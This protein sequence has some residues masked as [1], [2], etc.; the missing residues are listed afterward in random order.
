MKYQIIGFL[1]PEKQIKLDVVFFPLE[2]LGMFMMFLFSLG[3]SEFSMVSFI[4]FCACF[5]GFSFM[6][7][8]L[9]TFSCQNKM[10]VLTVCK[11]VHVVPGITVALGYLKVCYTQCYRNVSHC[12]LMFA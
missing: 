12:V 4:S 11:L 8:T 2:L 1:N 10:Q 9:L 7:K 5:V 6:L 3:S